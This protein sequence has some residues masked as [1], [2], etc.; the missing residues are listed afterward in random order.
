MNSGALAASPRAAVRG[1]AP[2]GVDDRAGAGTEAH[3][4]GEGLPD[5]GPRGCWASL[6]RCPRRRVRRHPLLRGEIDQDLV[7]PAWRPAIYA[8]ASLPEGSVDS[9]RERVPTG[10]I[11]GKAEYSQASHLRSAV[12]KRLVPATSIDVLT[13]GHLA[14]VRYRSA[15]ALHVD[16]ND[17]LGHECWHMISTHSAPR[18]NGDAS[19]LRGCRKI[20]VGCPRIICGPRVVGRSA[21]GSCSASPRP[22]MIAE[23]V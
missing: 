7:P 19:G 6:E 15:M 14:V 2:G 8:N 13:A 20:G 18:R 4:A 17:I 9:G 21:R 12:Y 23:T 22:A 3:G 1:R 16:G 10:A 11:W 5:A